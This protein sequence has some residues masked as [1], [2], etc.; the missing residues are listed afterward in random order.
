[1]YHLRSA[2]SGESMAPLSIPTG[3]IVS[4]SSGRSFIVCFRR[5]GRTSLGEISPPPLLHLGGHVDALDRGL[6]QHLNGACH[7]AELEIR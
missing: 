4:I 5:S 7:L 6:F 2:M 3:W 1:M